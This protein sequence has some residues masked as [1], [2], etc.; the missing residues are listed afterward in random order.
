MCPST[1]ILGR[2][3]GERLSKLHAT[4]VS[5]SCFPLNFESAVG[6]VL[7]DELRGQHSFNRK[8]G[9][10]IALAADFDEFAVAHELC[11]ALMSAR[12]FPHV[13]PTSEQDTVLVRLGPLLRN[14]LTHKTVKEYL[15][16]FGYRKE[17]S[18]HYRQLRRGIVGALDRLNPTQARAAEQ[19]SLGEMKDGLSLLEFLV[20]GEMNTDLRVRL[21]KKWPRTLAIADGLLRALDEFALDTQRGLRGGYVRL[22]REIVKHLGLLPTASRQILIDPV[23]SPGKATDPAERLFVLERVDDEKGILLFVRSREDGGYCYCL[24]ITEDEVGPWEER[25]AGLRAREFIESLESAGT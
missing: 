6:Q 18:H 22:I 12:E 20:T 9:H 13:G 5:E 15:T 23:L 3:F 7:K 16:Q 8:D 4:L 24:R 11:H 19:D 10:R 2:E 21:Q 1:V 14:S 25:L 17:N